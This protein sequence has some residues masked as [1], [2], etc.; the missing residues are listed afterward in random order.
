MIEQETFEEYMCKCIDEMPDDLDSIATQTVFAARRWDKKR[1]EKINSLTE[2]NKIL[3]EA[4]KFY[5]NYDDW[6]EFQSEGSIFTDDVEGDYYC[7]FRID[8]DSGHTARQALGEIE[9]LKEGGGGEMKQMTIEQALE[10]I[11][12]AVGNL[13]LSTESHFDTKVLGKFEGDLNDGRKIVISVTEE[14]GVR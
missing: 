10:N 12:I 11:L 6:A 5:S 8:L 2:Q 3:V 4:V 14:G 1:I 9:E 13:L 7:A